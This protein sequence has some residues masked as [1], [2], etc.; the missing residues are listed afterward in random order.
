MKCRVAC[1]RLLTVSTWVPVS[2]AALHVCI[3]NSQL[4]QRSSPF[5]S[6]GCLFTGACYINL[7]IIQVVFLGSAGPCALV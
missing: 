4:W 3:G 6:K 7:F 2:S 5:Q 1:L